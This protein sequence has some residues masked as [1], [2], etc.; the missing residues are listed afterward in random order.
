MV[1]I[2]LIIE[3]ISR[4][5]V[6]VQAQ[7]WKPK[8]DHITPDSFH[9]DFPTLGPNVGLCAAGGGCPPKGSVLRQQAVAA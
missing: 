6:K 3:S 7:R 1:H 4:E 2:K 8:V 5:G 9:M